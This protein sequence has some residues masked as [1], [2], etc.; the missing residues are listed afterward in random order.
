LEWKDLQPLLET[1]AA[2]P[3]PRK[4][5]R[6]T[7]RKAAANETDGDGTNLYARDEKVLANDNN[8]GRPMIYKSLVTMNIIWACGAMH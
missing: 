3:L 5:G 6:E 2:P 1:S 7:S 8:M 4:R